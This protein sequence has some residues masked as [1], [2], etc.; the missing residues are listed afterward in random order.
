MRA[1]LPLDYY[2]PLDQDGMFYHRL[3]ELR[4][5]RYLGQSQRR[6]FFLFGAHQFPWF[7]SELLQNRV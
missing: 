3:N 1:W 4:A 5:I 7:Q 2:G 6:V